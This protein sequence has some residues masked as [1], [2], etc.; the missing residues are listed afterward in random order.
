MHISSRRW[1]H[2][3]AVLIFA[4][5]TLLMGGLPL[6]LLLPA[7]WGYENGPL[8][9]AQVAIV[10][11]GFAASIFFLRK[12]RDPIRW[13][14]LA[15]APVLLVLIGRELSWGAVFLE[16][17]FT[18]SGAPVFTSRHLW[19]KPVVAPTV[20]AL[21]LVSAT[22]IILKRLDKSAID[23]CRRKGIPVVPICLMLVGGCWLHGLKESFALCQYRFG[24]ARMTPKS[25]KR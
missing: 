14:G 4:S 19:Y 12:E 25:W 7:N 22:A 23:V 21:I 16:P 24:S 3:A 18:R 13:F 2:L 17:E 5:S 8:E 20:A 11:L 15:A 1:R 10:A 6:A 9:N